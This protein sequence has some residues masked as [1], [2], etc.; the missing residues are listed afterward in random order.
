MASENVT[1]DEYDIGRFRSINPATSV[2]DGPLPTTH[3][4]K[5]GKHV[6]QEMIFG[7]DS[8]EMTQRAETSDMT[9]YPFQ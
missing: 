3:T 5:L 2:V 8:P 4:H 7:D 9:E 1:G 6:G